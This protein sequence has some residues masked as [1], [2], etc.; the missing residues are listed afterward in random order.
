MFEQALVRRSS[1]SGPNTQQAW[2]RF[3]LS[4]FSDRLGESSHALRLAVPEAL[5]R[6]PSR[7]HLFLPRHA[8][9]YLTVAGSGAVR[10]RPVSYCL[11]QPK[12]WS[13]GPLATPLRPPA[14]T[15]VRIT[16]LEQAFFP[17]PQPRFF[18]VPAQR[19]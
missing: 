10:Q 1:G 12:P 15:P 13:P 19:K 4:V 6:P 14:R 2:D 8:F 17:A 7:C 5:V 9:L 18:P 16:G 11:P 3:P